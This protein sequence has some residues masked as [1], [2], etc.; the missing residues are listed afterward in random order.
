MH[1][2]H[3]HII[4]KWELCMHSQLWF[5]TFNCPQLLGIFHIM[6][7]CGASIILHASWSLWFCGSKEGF[8]CCLRVKYTEFARI[9]SLDWNL[10]LRVFYR[11]K[12]VNSVWQVSGIRYSKTDSLVLVFSIIS[13]N[14]RINRPCWKN[15]NLYYTRMGAVSGQE[16]SPKA[17]RA[18]S[19]AGWQTL[20]EQAKIALT[21]YIL[22]R[23]CYFSIRPYLEYCIYYYYAL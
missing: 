15:Q 3:N 7:V 9:P 16:L 13:K 12:P 18:N 1:V 8:S 6:F 11:T 5:W 22:T 20:F 23:N 21:Y 19:H 10:G 2:H 14:H 17:Q 4:E